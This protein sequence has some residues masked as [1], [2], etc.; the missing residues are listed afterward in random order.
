[1]PEDPTVI[2]FAKENEYFKSDLNRL[3]HAKMLIEDNRSQEAILCLEA[4]VQENKE[5]SEAWRILG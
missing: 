2:N 4:E 5:N 1:M 3:D